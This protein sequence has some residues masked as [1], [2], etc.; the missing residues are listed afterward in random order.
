MYFELQFSKLILQYKIGFSCIFSFEQNAKSYTV[1]YTP[2][3]IQ[4]EKQTAVGHY[5][6][7]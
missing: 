6:Y 3:P 2:V 1:K 5:V 7:N 4:T